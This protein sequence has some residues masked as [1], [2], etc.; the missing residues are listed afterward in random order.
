METVEIKIE[1][2]G[3]YSL[4]GSYA[5]KFAKDFA[6]DRIPRHV[7]FII[8]NFL[9]RLDLVREVELMKAHFP[10]VIFEIYYKK[11]D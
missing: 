2:L 1:W 3:V 7:I 10:E 11:K 6:P 9:E 4:I 8:E 5:S